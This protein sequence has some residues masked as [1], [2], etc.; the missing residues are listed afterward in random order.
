MTP[1]Q[2]II[3]Q[4]MTALRDAYNILNSLLPS[5][6]KQEQLRSRGA[7][8]TSDRTIR[9]VKDVFGVN[10]L[11]CGR[12][13]ENVLARHAVRY[14]LRKHTLRS[15]QSIGALTGTNDHKSVLHSIRVA[16]NLIE[17]DANYAELITKCEE[18]I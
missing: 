10:P 15:L 8:Y 16:E 9:V 4:S 2:E 11:A 5:D 1:S 7:D 6:S 3:E 18:I 13:K 17:K 12:K 14:L